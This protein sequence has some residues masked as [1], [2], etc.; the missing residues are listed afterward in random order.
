MTIPTGPSW[1]GAGLTDIG[2]VRKINQDAFSV[3]NQ[4]QLWVLADGMGGHAGGEVAA[5]MAVDTVPEYIGKKVTTNPTDP[6][7]ALALEKLLI[8]ALEWA[9]TLIREKASHNPDIKGMGTT[10]VAVAMTRDNDQHQAVIAHAGDSRAYVLRDQALTLWTKDHTLMEDQLDLN[11]ITPE[12][13]KTHPLRHVVTRGLGIEPQARPTVKTYPL[14]PTDLLL[15]CSDG[16]TK[17]L[18][19]AE[20][21]TLMKRDAP[22]LERM[23]QTFVKTANRLGGE[24]NTTVVVIGIAPDATLGDAQSTSE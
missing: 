20:I 3:S 8:E 21:Q 13:V 10:V 14:E 5:Q 2:R 11:I 15:L 4:H 19:D 24:D 7:P 22:N 9:N 16:L 12:Q 17:M 6:I 23:T 18:S 1:R